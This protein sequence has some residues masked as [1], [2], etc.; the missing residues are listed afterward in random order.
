[1]NKPVQVFDGDGVERKAPVR[2]ELIST[3]VVEAFATSTEECKDDP[4][5]LYLVIRKPADITRSD[6]GM[7]HVGDVLR[8]QFEDLS[9]L[10]GKWRLRHVEGFDTEIIAL[11]IEPLK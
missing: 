1:M 11:T 3:L 6:I 7:L 10:K 8:I 2:R 4:G 9:T 5:W